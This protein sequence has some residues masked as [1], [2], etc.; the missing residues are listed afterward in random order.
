MQ[1]TGGAGVS[2]AGLHILKLCVGVEKVEELAVSQTRRSAERRAAGEDSRPRHVTRLWPRRKAEILAGGSLYWIVK[3]RML[4]RQR[5]TAM[6]PADLGDGINRC[7]IMLDPALVLVEPV[8]RRPFQ[9]WRYL[10]AADAPADLG[11]TGAPGDLP[12]PLRAALAEIGV[13]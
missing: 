2:A 13:R 12:A 3:G 1:M 10:N 6:E 9:G 8:I 11:G 4:V 5:I 7:A